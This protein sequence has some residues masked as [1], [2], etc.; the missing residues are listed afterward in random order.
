ML[1]II[2][3]RILPKADDQ[4]AFEIMRLMESALYSD[5]LDVGELMEHKQIEKHIL[6]YIASFDSD[7][8]RVAFSFMGQLTIVLPDIEVVFL[9]QPVVKVVD[10]SRLRIQLRSAQQDSKMQ[11]YWC[12]ANILADPTHGKKLATAIIDSYEFTRDLVSLAVQEYGSFFFGSHDLILGLLYHASK[13]QLMELLERYH[14][15]EAP[16]AAIQRDQDQR[17]VQAGLL[18]LQEV[19][20][21]CRKAF[22][23]KTYEDNPS[24]K[25]ILYNERFCNLLDG[26][27]QSKNKAISEAAESILSEH[28]PTLST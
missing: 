14:L 1:K 11:V 16:F 22:P 9:D 20:L 27:L 2:A 26:L 24:V 6:E 17:S 13:T 10:L 15:L 3:D 28:F 8:I 19:V 4:I 25:L 21:V 23:V 18:L 5:E 12:L 7:R